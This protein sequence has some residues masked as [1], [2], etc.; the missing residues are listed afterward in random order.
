ME[1]RMEDRK[2]ETRNDFRR[3]SWRFI[4]MGVYNGWDENRVCA[5]LVNPETWT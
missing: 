4:V 2:R 1:R 5:G 3:F